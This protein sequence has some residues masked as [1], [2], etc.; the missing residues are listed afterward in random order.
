LYLLKLLH[1]DWTWLRIHELWLPE[2][3]VNLIWH[4]GGDTHQCLLLLNSSNILL[5]FW[6]PFGAMTTS[7]I[8]VVKVWIP[9]VVVCEF[10]GSSSPSPSPSPSPGC[11]SSSCAWSIVLIGLRIFHV[12]DVSWILELRSPHHLSV[13]LSCFIPFSDSSSVIVVRHDVLF[14]LMKKFINCFGFLSCQ[15]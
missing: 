15:M 2:A 5:G 7:V 9:W 10:R 8:L 6:A 3:W 13:A 1:Y 14:K 11:K 12:I 4:Y